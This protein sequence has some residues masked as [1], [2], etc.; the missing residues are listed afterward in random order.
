LTSSNSDESGRIL[1]PD[2]LSGA[3]PSLNQVASEQNG[4]L[5]HRRRACAND[6]KRCRF[7]AVT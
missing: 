2:P 1:A 6:A 5:R 4:K 7:T 3:N